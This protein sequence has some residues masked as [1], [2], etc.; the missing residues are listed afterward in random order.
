MSCLNSYFFVVMCKGFLR[1]R[2]RLDD[3]THLSWNSSIRTITSPNYKRP[4]IYR[5]RHNTQAQPNSRFK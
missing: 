3:K 1:I 5:L 2:Q 4:K